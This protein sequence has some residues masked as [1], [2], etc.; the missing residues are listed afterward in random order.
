MNTGEIRTLYAFNRWANR[1]LLEAVA[2]LTHEELT[3]D[4]A[5]SY[6]SVLGTLLHIFWAEWLWLERW[7]GRS[8]RQGDLPVADLQDAA[9]VGARWRLLEVEQQRFIDAL[10][11]DALPRRIAY[12]NF[13]GETWEY[14]LAHMMQHVVNHSSYHRGQVVTLLRQLGRKPPMTDLLFYFDEIGGD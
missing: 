8:P 7:L 10:I 1:R 9:S 4:M 12:Q 11:D 14:T 5:T 2:A 3:R 6:T 13:A